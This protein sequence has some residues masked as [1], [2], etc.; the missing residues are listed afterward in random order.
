[1]LRT[2]THQIGG[3]MQLPECGK[4]SARTLAPPSALHGL[5]V[6]GQTFLCKNILHV[7]PICGVEAWSVY[8]PQTFACVTSQR[9]EQADGQAN[10]TKRIKKQ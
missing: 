6:G 9:S 2:K 4:D 7:T 8:L 5:R 10:R 1:M 3:K